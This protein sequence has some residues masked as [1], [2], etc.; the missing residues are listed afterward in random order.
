MKKP[1]LII[2]ILV[3][4]SSAS[5]YKQILYGQYDE[6]LF[7]KYIDLPIL[8]VS[9]DEKAGI[10]GWLRVAV[11]EGENNIIFDDRTNIDYTTIA[12]ALKAITFAESYLN[13]KHDYFISYD[14]NSEKVSG[15]STGSAIAAGIIALSKN[16]TLKDNTLITGEVDYD[17]NLIP[18]GGIPIKTAVAAASGYTEII[19]PENST[20]YNVY[21]K[22][23]NYY[24]T[25]QLDMMDYAREKYNIQL[26][27]CTNMNLCI[28]RI[29]E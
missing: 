10:Q 19:I 18:V 17:G 16:T 15:S 5:A 11:M 29:I 14:L 22:H 3:L 13:E 8:A 23:E 27:E 2:M 4:I 12:S 24:V 25:R 7:K 21:E 6:N 9:S 1:V 20:I 26:T 28:N